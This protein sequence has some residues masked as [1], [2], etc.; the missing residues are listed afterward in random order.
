M[1]VNP[2]LK[3]LERLFSFARALRRSLLL[4]NWWVDW[5]VGYC[6]IRYKRGQSAH[7]QVSRLWAVT[8][9][10]SWLMIAVLCKSSLWSFEDSRGLRDNM[11]MRGCHP[12]IYIAERLSMSLEKVSEISPRSTYGGHSS[13]SCQLQ[14]NPSCEAYS[15]FIDQKNCT[16]W[17]KAWETGAMMLPSSCE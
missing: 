6:Q 7:S 17:N 11:E 15:L 14:F 10:W 4:S 2:V 1:H 13:Q 3:L 12:R 5:L 9:L 8:S 16:V